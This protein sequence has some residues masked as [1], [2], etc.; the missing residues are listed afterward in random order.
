LTA[1]PQTAIFHGI[2]SASEDNPPVVIRVKLPD[3]DQVV[4]D[5]D[6]AVRVYGALDPASKK[7]GYT[8]I[9]SQLS[10][11]SPDIELIK[12]LNKGTDLNTPLGVFGYRGRIP[13]NHITE[14]G[15]ALQEGW[16]DEGTDY[17]S[18]FDNIKEF[19]DALEIYHEFG[20]YYRG[21]EEEIEDLRGEEQ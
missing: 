2:N 11:M 8:D 17:W 9:F 6:T 7:L 16:R 12:N 14:I 10:Y 21:M 5:Y 13:A 4:W 15:A 19:K 18:W 20:Q 3:K 1:I